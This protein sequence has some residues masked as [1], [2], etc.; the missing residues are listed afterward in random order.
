MISLKI[1]ISDCDFKMRGDHEEEAYGICVPALKEHMVSCA[2][3]QYAEEHCDFEALFYEAGCEFDDSGAIAMSK[4]NCLILEQDIER[5]TARGQ[6]FLDLFGYE[7]DPSND[8]QL[9]INTC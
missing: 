9:T 5:G 2:F 4:V 7:E 3:I 6:D 8:Y 1:V